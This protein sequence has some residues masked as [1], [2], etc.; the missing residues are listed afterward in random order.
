MPRPPL[1]WL[2]VASQALGKNETRATK[3]TLSTWHG[4]Y[5]DFECGDNWRT[6]DADIKSIPATS[7]R[8]CL[9]AA[10]M[11]L[12]QMQFHGFCFICQVFP[13]RSL[14]PD[15]LFFYSEVAARIGDSWRYSC[16][17]LLTGDK[18]QSIR[19]VS[20]EQFKQDYRQML[21]YTHSC[22]FPWYLTTIVFHARRGALFIC[23]EGCVVFVIL[24]PTQNP[25]TLIWSDLMSTFPG[26]IQKTNLTLCKSLVLP[27]RQTL[28]SF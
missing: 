23:S 3:W 18:I 21:L 15:I 13:R 26:I 24:G 1:S 22:N 14:I 17:S 16:R 9:V 12:A 6:L 2:P 11:N 10:K 19:R 7:L 28:L 5:Y 20:G 8:R 25:W 27:F 4:A